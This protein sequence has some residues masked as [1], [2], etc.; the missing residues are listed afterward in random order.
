MLRTPP[1]VSLQ[2][3]AC[4][5]DG[6]DAQLRGV[7]YLQQPSG[8]PALRRPSND[9]RTFVCKVFR[10][11]F[12][13]WVKEENNLSRVR[14]HASQIRAFVLIAGRTSQGEIVGGVVPLVLAWNDVL[15]VETQL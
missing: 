13:P 5:Q 8:G 6:P 11:V 15:N 12:A 1:R 2:F 9:A 7:V 4:V 3:T 10:P 14:L